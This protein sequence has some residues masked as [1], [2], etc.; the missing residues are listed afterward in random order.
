[1]NEPYSRVLQRASWSYQ[2]TA[3][4]EVVKEGGLPRRRQHLADVE[5]Q[6]GVA[7]EARAEI[8]ERRQEAAK[9]GT[10]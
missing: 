3:L 7:K 10:A 1:M 4:S 2:D 9:L 6:G 8:V 5:R